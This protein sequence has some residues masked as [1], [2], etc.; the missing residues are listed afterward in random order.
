MKR[1]S[2][3]TY[4]LKFS[5]GFTLIELMIAS[6]LY[7]ILISIATGAFINTLRTQRIITDL[8]ESLNNTSFAIEQIA[9]EVRVG[10]D[11]EG[12]GGTLEFTNSNGNGVIYELKNQTDSENG[13]IWRCENGSDCEFMTAPEVNIDN[14]EFILMGSEPGDDKSPRITILISVVGEKNIRVDMQT[15]ISSRIL[16]S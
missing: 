16:D 3:K 2:P 11:F 12:E 9:R 13:G 4:H 15:T 6:G 8:S 10:F 14:L 7:I 1:L 5:S